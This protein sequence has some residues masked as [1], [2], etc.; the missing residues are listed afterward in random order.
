LGRVGCEIREEKRELE[1]LEEDG[2]G[3]EKD[4]ED[5]Q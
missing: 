4:T 1:E 3:A 5:G 2:K